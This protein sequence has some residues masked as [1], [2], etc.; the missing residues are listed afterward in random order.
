MDETYENPEDPASSARTEHQA[1]DDQGLAGIDNHDDLVRYTLGD[2]PLPQ[3]FPTSIP[4]QNPKALP[5]AELEP[6]VFERLA[7][8][9]VARR[10][11]STK[12][13]FYGRRG[14]KQYGL[15]VV[16]HHR[17]FRPTLYQVRR[18]Q[19]LQPS[20][21]TTAVRDFAGDPRPSTPRR[22]DPEKFV[23]VT[24]AE[25]DSDS[26]NLDQL[27]A[28]NDEYQ[29]DLEIEVWGVETLS[30][31]LRDQP[32]LVFAMFG[33]H[34][35]DAWCGFRPTPEELA[36]P[37]ALAF[38]N[39]PAEVLGLSA[40][41]IAAASDE[42]T[43]PREAAN[44]YHQI[45]EAFDAK[46]FPAHASSVRLK[47]SAA[48][49]S[50]GDTEGA[51]DVQF[52]VALQ[53]VRAGSQLLILSPAS[54]AGLATN[55][56]QKAKA[57]LIATLDAWAEGGVDLQQAL[58]A[59]KTL[60]QR[61]DSDFSELCLMTAEHALVDGLFDFHP[62]TPPLMPVKST[63]LAGDLDEFRRLLGNA[64]S[65][66]PLLRAR[67][68]CLL[69]D[70]SL[71]LTS[72]RADIE[73]AYAHVTDVILQN[74]YL[75]AIGLAKSRRAYA[76]AV[77]A[78]FETART[79][80]KSSIKDSCEARCDADAREA[81][82]SIRDLEI[83]AGQLTTP[84]AELL[85]ALTGDQRRLAQRPD[86]EL[87]ALDAAHHNRLPDALGDARRY[88]WEARLAGQRDRE[89]HAMSLL[90]D[91]LEAAGQP[92]PAVIAHISAGNADAAERIAATQPPLDL[93]N[94][95]SIKDQRRRSAIIRVIGAQAHRYP[96][97]LVPFV[98]ALL[99][100]YA[101]NLWAEISVFEPCPVRDAINALINLGLRIPEFAVDD[102]LTLAR[103]TVETVDIFGSAE[104]AE[105]LV[106]TYCAVP[107]RRSDLAEVLGQRMAREEAT[108]ELW[109]VV[110]QIPGDM[111][112]E[113]VPMVLSAAASAR[114][115]PVACAA[116]W[117]LT[118]VP[119]QIAARQAAAHLLRRPL[120]TNPGQQAISLAESA[121]VTL[122]M[123]LLNLDDADLIDVEVEALASDKAGP[124]AGVIAPIGSADS[125]TQDS[126]PPEAE[127]AADM[128][129]TGQSGDD[130]AR[131]AAGPRDQLAA[132]V[133]Q[134]LIAIAQNSLEGSGTRVNTL[135]A[136]S[137]LAEYLDQRMISNA[138]KAAE[139][140]FHNP[141]YSP[142]DDTVRSWDHGLSRVH[143]DTGQTLLRAIALAAAAS[144][145]RIGRVSATAALPPDSDFVSSL[146]AGAGEL[147]AM[148]DAP[149]RRHGA[150][151]FFDLVE[152]G[153]VSRE[154]LT[155]FLGDRD[156]EIR[157]RAV[158]AAQ[159]GTAWLAVLARDGA[160]EVRAQVARR[161]DLPDDIRLVLLGDS[162]PEVSRSAK[163]EQ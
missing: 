116:A 52:G 60:E 1:P 33:P 156:S 25:F 108:P 65:H 114:R 155:A 92:R 12:V 158:E 74:G 62:P 123:G 4:T 115:E 37:N 40:A 50:A 100:K 110:E 75:D 15:D 18:L 23:L 21:I 78:D 59:L 131:I 69:A 105:L 132:A 148:D 103:P 73:T 34:W 157:S 130:A 51:F 149:I 63:D 9:F 44:V 147:L 112:A 13:H 11:H 106:N 67:I 5:L 88:L 36:A 146:L 122:L 29:G 77:R 72:D 133:A 85:A 120:N 91:V 35:A 113:L 128:A 83:G 142:I 118:G 80:W 8:E 30:R 48:L 137:Q 82:F 58:P 150:D 127:T 104:I 151:V 125:A 141:A 79:W 90:A 20:D 70:A 107:T 117:K 6:E 32:R 49:Q 101:E 109:Q 95:L 124:A 27:D 134:K 144:I 162:D 24:S 71:T 66:D 98:A 136:I 143:L 159:P 26:A 96:D 19:F 99:L 160:A 126:G 57:V 161:P 97:E 94:W 46:R 145:Y 16:E 152:A 14:Q 53:H 135:N 47:E 111:R 7:A 41:L 86:P 61:D 93:S 56:L 153:D 42:S 31:E 55:E 22:F 119:N 54:L 43:K 2:L 139:E 76:H 17:Q 28:L 154:T 39:D 10:S 89:R 45:A 129:P 138:A 68:D 87:L 140:I 81:M 102:I 64:T 121:T 163:R 3:Q 38:N 84:I